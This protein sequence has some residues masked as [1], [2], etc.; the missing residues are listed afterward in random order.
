MTI[1]AGQDITLAIGDDADPEAA[2]FSLL[3]GIR[4]S[5]LRIDAP[6]FPR[7][8]AAGSAW[9]DVAAAGGQKQLLVEGEGLFQN[10]QGEALLQY[11]ALSGGKTSL[12]CTFGNG[13]T[14]QCPV[15]LTRFE[16]MQEPQAAERYRFSLVNA[17]EVIYVHS[18]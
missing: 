15:R 4:I 7:R 3:E 16:R 12:H 11:Y 17:G 10:S 14:L 18:T 8:N 9:R 6:I 13:D 5:L 2:A 1:Y